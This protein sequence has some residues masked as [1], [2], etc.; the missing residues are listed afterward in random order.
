M[1]KI[2]IIVPSFM[3]GQLLDIKGIKKIELCISGMGKV[4][5]ALG[6]VELIDKGC[7][8]ILLT[9]YAGA[10]RGLKMGDVVTPSYIY[11]GDYHAEPFENYPNCITIQNQFF[12]KAKNCEIVTQ[13]TFLK[14]NIYGH[15]TRITSIGHFERL[16]TDMEA[17]AVAYFCGR[18]GIELYI[19]KIISDVV[20]AKSEKNFLDSC[21][22][23][24]EQL[25]VVIKKSIQQIRKEK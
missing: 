5:A 16:A 11:E 17:Y 12:E 21:T 3:E 19:T 18:L 25:S 22:K 14:K 6:V 20:G 13:D 4:R 2:G 1:K 7:T 9:G 15:P 8:S 23:L 24:S 10:L